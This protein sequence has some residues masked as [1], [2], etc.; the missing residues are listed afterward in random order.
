MNC[1]K[2]KAFATSFLEMQWLTS[3]ENLA[4][5]PESFFRWRLAD[6]VPLD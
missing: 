6:L 1:E 4:V 5:L 2:P 3:L